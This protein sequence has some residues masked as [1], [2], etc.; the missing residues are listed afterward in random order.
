M[1]GLGFRLSRATPGWGVG[2]C[3]FVCALRLYPAT[4]SW[5]VWRGCVW[6]GLGF[7]CAPPLLAAVLGCVCAGVRAPLVP[8]HSWLGC[9][10]WVCV[11]RPGFQ[12][13]RAT[14]GCGVGVCVFV[15]AL[16]LY[17]ATPSWVVRRGCVC[18]GSGFGCAPPLL[19]AVLRCVCVRVRVPLV[20]HHSWLGC[21]VW[22]CVFGL[23]FRLCPATPG[24][25]VGVCALVCTLLVYPATP[26]SG[27]RCGCVCSGL[28]FGCALPLL[29]R[30]L[31]SLCVFVRAPPVPR[32][33]WLGCALWVCVLGL[34]FW[35]RLATPDWAVGECVFLCALRVYPGTPGWGL[36]TVSWLLP[37]TCSPDVVSCVLCA[38]PGFAAPVGR[39]CLARPRVPWLSPAACLSGV[40]RGPALV[41]RTSSCLVALETWSVLQD[42]EY[43]PSPFLH[44][45]KHGKAIALPLPL[46]VT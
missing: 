23:V 9:A 14:P 31:G 26:G 22:V 1:F 38:L 12:L 41:R 40:P 6:L 11:F 13:R 15:C 44:V 7:G 21:A 35:L 3:V 36:W 34:G 8:R 30:V 32:H 39:C 33:S 45:L 2:V 18:L 46:C 17:P 4:P 42:H 10:V 5:V 20:P 29:A 16:R 43:P 25:R 28:G 27:V 24:W 19:A 37:G